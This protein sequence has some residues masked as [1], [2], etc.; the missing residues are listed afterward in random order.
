MIRIQKRLVTAAL[1]LLLGCKEEAKKDPAATPISAAPSV[2]SQPPAPGGSTS[3]SHAAPPFVPTP[4]EKMA[5]LAYFAGVWKCDVSRVA[6]GH[7][8]AKTYQGTITVKDDLGGFWNS[9]RNES[10]EATVAGFSGYDRSS[11]RFLRVAFDS[12]GGME[13]KTSDGWK[14]DDFVWSGT[15]SVAGKDA[16]LKHTITKHGDKEFSGTYEIEEDGKWQSIR[17]EVCKKP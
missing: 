6:R 12:Y 5:Q 14:G 7:I 2:R 1:V 3:A 13:T 8:P 4:S 10:T 9:I 11:Q 16:P 17:T 15:S